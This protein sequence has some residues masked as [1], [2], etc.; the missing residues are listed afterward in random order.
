MSPEG[1]RE[2]EPKEVPKYERFLELFSRHQ[3]Q[4][5]ALIRVLVPD[6]ATSQ[7]V[8]QDTSLELWR[9]FDSY[10]AGAPF[11]PWAAIIAKR[12]VIRSWRKKHS[13]QTGFSEELLESLT[14]EFVEESEVFEQRRIALRTCVRQL[15][16][17]QQELLK[18]F[19]L[20]SETVAEISLTWHRSVHGIYKALKVVRKTLADCVTKKLEE[21][22]DNH[23]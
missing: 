1:D 21:S 5:L 17:R 16:S 22:R 4:I 2:L 8:F 3:H 20:D 14:T 19:Y 18:R 10:R 11:L 6:Y 9:S 23:G 7:D 15:P 12:Q 13:V